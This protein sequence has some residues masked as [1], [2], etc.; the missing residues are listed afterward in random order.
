MVENIKNINIALT[1]KCNLKCIMCDIWKESPKIDISLDN[2]NNILQSECLDENVDISLTGGEPFLHE[3][4]VEI[5]QIIL[6]NKPD[7]L[8]TISTNGYLTGN[9]IDYL[10]E[11]NSLLPKGFSLHISLDG[12]N[13][14]D[15]QRG[16]SGLIQVMDTIKRVKRNFPLLNIKIK[17]V[18]T[19]LNYSD[20]LPTYYFCKSNR[21][22][23]RVKLVEHA[24]NYTNKVG[25]AKFNFDETIRKRIAKDLYVIYSEKNGDCKDNA[26]FIKRI[27][28]QLLN[29]GE[30]INCKT[31]SERI[32]VMPNADVYSC[33]HFGSIGNLNE[34]FLD[35]IW[36]S[37][38]A[39]SVRKEVKK[40]KCNKCVSYHGLTH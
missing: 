16:K 14:H 31:P 10:A 5:T 17:F 38:K 13:A 15:Q 9:I 27:I 34:N 35:D 11:F 22:D 2:I 12:I 25:R 21:M 24:K 6:K 3:K 33:I 4:L 28:K 19:P 8:K 20:L 26:E 32:F 7:S 36:N 40:N 30:P 39:N 23:F 1:N 29:K 37:T 18:I